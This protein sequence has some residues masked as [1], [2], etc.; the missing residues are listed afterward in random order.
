MTA[1][2]QPLTSRIDDTSDGNPE[3]TDRF[4]ELIHGDERVCDNC[5]RQIGEV[6][7]RAYDNNLYRDR[8]PEPVREFIA[9]HAPTDYESL[10]PL[11][12]THDQPTRGMTGCCTCGAI[13]RS[14]VDRPVPLRVAL[15][16]TARA[17]AW[18]DRNGI[19]INRLEAITTA[20]SLLRDPDRQHYQDT[21]I[22]VAC[23]VA[24]ND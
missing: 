7:A 6:H 24:I 10:T 18:Y 8:D 17:A 14:T 3:P 13:R 5:Y 22:S 2:S 21:V 16:L 19:D 9:D 12:A 20:A 1:V 23:E 11:S 15:V 4:E